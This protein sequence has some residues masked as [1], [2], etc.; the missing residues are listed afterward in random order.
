M[1]NA[2]NALRIVNIN[3][4]PDLSVALRR[5]YKESFSTVPHC[6][7]QFGGDE[8]QKWIPIF[9]EYQAIISSAIRYV[10]HLVEQTRKR[11]IEEQMRNH[12]IK[13]QMH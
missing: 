11:L 10:D 6:I 13:Q 8:T 2:V 5:I 3:N 1:E 4:T 9:Q 7:G 12:R